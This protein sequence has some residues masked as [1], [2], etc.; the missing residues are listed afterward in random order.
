MIPIFIDYIIPIIYDSFVTL[1]IV[2]LI[3]FIFRIKDSGIRILFFFLPLIKPFLVISERFQPYVGTR[4]IPT[5]YSGLRIP[6]PN[7]LI[8][9]FEEIDVS[10]NLFV[11]DINYLLIFL[12]V[13]A[14]LLLLIIRWFNLYLLYRRLSIEEKVTR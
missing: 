5:V 8:S 11:A 9:W 12:S 14:I 7:N 1:I 4:D 6:D 3:L 13:M 2:L 10:R